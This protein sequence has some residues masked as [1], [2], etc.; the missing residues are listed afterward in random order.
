MTRLDGIRNRVREHLNLSEEV[1][2]NPTQGVKDRLKKSTERI[3]LFLI[4]DLELLIHSATS[5]QA[6]VEL[7]RA[8]DVESERKEAWRV[9]YR[10]RR[11]VLEKALK[12]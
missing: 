7:G 10:K 5:A 3:H 8:E 6:L 2:T 11:E 9:E 1:M 12:E 4:G